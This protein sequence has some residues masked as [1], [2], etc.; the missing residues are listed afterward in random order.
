MSLCGGPHALYVPS[1][2][3]HHMC[4][5]ILATPASVL[6]HWR[7][8]GAERGVLLLRAGAQCGQKAGTFSG[9]GWDAGMTEEKWQEGLQAFALAAAEAARAD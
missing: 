6:V 5:L 7:R 4:P 2:I 9:I 8:L 1:D 3:G